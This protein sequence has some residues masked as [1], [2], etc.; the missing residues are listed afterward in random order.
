[1]S[2]KALLS[3]AIAAGLMFS[4]TIAAKTMTMGFTLSKN[5]HYGQ[6]AD[7]FAQEIEKLSG[8]KY[9]I[10]I[11]P[12]GVLGGE[13]DV[14]EGLQFGT[15]DL[16]ISSTGPIGNFVPEVYALDFPFLFKSY[17]H[18]HKIL[19]GE[20]GKDLLAKFEP[21][22]LIGLAWS[23]NGFRHLTNSKRIVRNPEDMKGLK[24]RTMENEVHMSAFKDLGAAPT[25]MS[26]TELFTALQQK[27]VDGQENPIPV[28]T[29]S[30]FYEVQKNVTL[31]GHVYSPAAIIMSK[32]TWDSLNSE[33]QMWFRQAAKVS[34]LATR[35]AVAKMERDGVE[36]LKKEGVTIVENI[37]KESF[38]KA[39]SKTYDKY[40]PKYGEDLIMKIRNTK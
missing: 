3:I 15:I 5:S 37:D 7:A 38:A 20:I 17:E 27:T 33:E 34:T 9:E 24:L 32:I 35:N 25:P 26:F 28:I 39:V 31:T 13:R 11:K 1:M 19:D 16:T 40:A 30:K 4:G 14:V 8:G 22:G 6:G 36:L 10:N 2:N 12:S 21:K 29:T 18:A 23:E